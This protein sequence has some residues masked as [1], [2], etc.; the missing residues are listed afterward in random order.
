M[1][2]LRKLTLSRW[3]H[4]IVAIISANVGEGINTPGYTRTVRTLEAKG[5]RLV[6]QRPDDNAAGIEIIVGAD[7]LPRLL[8]RTHNIQG[9]NLFSTPAGYVVWGELPDWSSPDMDPRD[10]SAVTITINRIDVDSLM[11]INPPLENLWKLDTIGITKEPF[12]HLEEKEVDLFKGTTQYK[13]RKYVV[14][15]PFKC[16]KHPASNYARAFAQFMSVKKSKNPQL[17]TD[18][19]KILDEYLEENF[20]EPVPLGTPVNGKVHYLPP[21]PVVKNSATTPIRIVF[22]A[23]SRS[24][25]NSLSLNDSL[26]TGPNIASKIQS[27]IIMFPRS[28]LV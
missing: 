20:I 9:V 17:F 13:T 28:P 10:V 3:R 27:M 19:R 23:S 4:K 24:N 12:S 26:Y 14:Q 5:I 11:T 8:E 6:D 25:Q 7:Y 16:D 2:P 18:Y 21:H 22:N 15:L 1:Q